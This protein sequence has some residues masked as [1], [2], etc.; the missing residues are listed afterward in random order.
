MSDQ[1]LDQ[2]SLLEQVYAAASGELDW[3]TLIDSLCVL[4]NADKG[5]LFCWDKQNMR[6]SAIWQ[7]GVDPD[8]QVAYQN[9]YGQIDPLRD[10]IETQPT[11]RMLLCQQFIDDAYVQKSE[12]YQDF[13]LRAGIRYVGGCN[14][15]N[16]SALQ[17]V[18][19]FQSGPQR[20]P[21]QP[22]DFHLLKGVESHMARALRLYLELQHF[23]RLQNIFEDI[24][25]ALLI[26]CTDG[27]LLFANRAGECLLQSGTSWM[28]REGR[29]GLRHAEHNETLQ[30]ALSDACQRQ[31]GHDLALPRVDTAGRLMSE[32]VEVSPC[33]FAGYHGT[34][35]VLIGASR[36]AGPPQAATLMQTFGLSPA[37]TRVALAIAAGKA[38]ADY[39]AE[40]G[41][42]LATV[43]TQLRSTFRKAGCDRQA[44]LVRKMDL[45]RP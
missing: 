37:E 5:S 30:H 39:A 32:R 35:L 38:P 33:H 3:H 13:M 2:I 21:F 17:A 1:H 24:P 45:L 20:R 11:G 4:V 34:A 43:R 19:S 44:E 42:S 18:L 36:Q 6:V 26:L 7:I 14:L 28:I 9:H 10:F 40:A 22:E 12:Y 29:V 8:N 15:I 23:Q 27:R 41:L 31:V 16:D 25:R